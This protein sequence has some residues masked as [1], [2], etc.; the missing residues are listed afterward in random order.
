MNI[1]RQIGQSRI[2]RAVLCWLIAQYVRLVWYSGRWRV[3][4]LEHPGPYWRD[5]RP[6][7]G[8]FWHGRL[9]MM[10]YAWQTRRR[11]NVLISHH[12]DGELIAGA[13][14]HLGVATVRGSSR[15]GG[16]DAVRAMLRCLRAREYVAITPD[17]PRGPAR[18]VSEGT[19]HT[20]WL[21]GVPIL[22]ATYSTT[23]GRELGSWDRFHLALPFARGVLLWGAPIEVPRD[24]D[25]ATLEEIRR[26][27][28]VR[29]DALTEE[30]DRL[31][32]RGGSDA[33]DARA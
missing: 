7:I 17:G 29:L 24:A 16:A 9:L 18:R 5:G 11:M 26:L 13:M 27:V 4:G 8:V 31:C 12:R 2:A 23:R 28:E 32:G 20:A 15:H 10:A 1:G 25:S 6:F 22:P 30:A 33:A 21:A 14:G 19:V 3:L